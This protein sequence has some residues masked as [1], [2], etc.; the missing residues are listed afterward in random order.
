MRTQNVTSQ[1][2]Q[3]APLGLPPLLTKEE[4]AELV[5]C[6]RVIE[7]GLGTFIDVGIALGKVRV[8]KLYR[9]EYP[10]FEAYCAQKWGITPRRAR[11]I[12]DAA[13]VVRNIADGNHG[14]HLPTPTSERQVRDLTSLPPEEQK[15]VWGRAVD[16][17]GGV[18][19]T[20]KQ[21]AE[22]KAEIK[23]TKFSEV[24]LDAWIDIVR[25]W[26]KPGDPLS[27]AAVMGHKRNN[28]NT[29]QASAIFDEMVER[30]FVEDGKFIDPSAP[31][32]SP[33]TPA[34]DASVLRLAKHIF[35]I[36]M[37]AA[38]FRGSWN[39]HREEAK[40]GFVAIAQWHIETVKNL[41]AEHMKECDVM[42]RRYA[43]LSRDRGDKNGF[44]V[45]APPRLAVEP[46][47][48]APASNNGKLPKA[49]RAILRVLANYPDGKTRGEIGVIAGYKHTGGGFNNALGSLRTSGYVYGSDPVKITDAGLQ[50]FGPVEPLPTGKELFD[51]WMQHPDLGRAE[52]EILRVYIS[53]K[54]MSKEEIAPL[55]ISDRGA[56]YEANG[57]GFNNAVGKLR[58]YELIE[59]DY[60]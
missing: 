48:A 6:E 26:L 22:A 4:E 58:A 43:E 42:Q 18:A 29:E 14:S 9:A 12:S 32:E 28:F 56:P 17:A 46:V 35:G 11:Q 31:D 7:R 44:P 25:S 50:A 40:A 59:G 55:T 39:S 10:T 57:G 15:E 47:P 1:T 41:A 8:G 13:E 45:G 16:S 52:C 19:P 27:V 3:G 60:K 53:A 30:G 5:L 20:G 33:E 37:D 34:P 54:A 49:E 38:H 36:A 24:Q 51:Y 21:V 2:P 23:G